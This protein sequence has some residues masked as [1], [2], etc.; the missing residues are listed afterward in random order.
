MH[1]DNICKDDWMAPEVI[2]GMDYDEKV[3]HYAQLPLTNV[4]SDVF[5]YGVLLLEFIIGTRTVKKELKRHPY[6]AFELDL[7]NIEYMY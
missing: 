3:P 5:S 1:F 4:K 6:Q 7:G 2:L